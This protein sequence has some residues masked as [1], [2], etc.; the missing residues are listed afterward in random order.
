MQPVMSSTEIAD[1]NW[2]TLT[3]KVGIDASQAT[4]FYQTAVVFVAVPGF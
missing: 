4:G 1:P 3:Y 2:A